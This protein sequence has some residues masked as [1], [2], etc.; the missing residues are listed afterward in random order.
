M[1]VKRSYASHARG[2]AVSGGGIFED[3]VFWA[4]FA[5][6]GGGAL[7][8]L[9]DNEVVVKGASFVS[10]STGQG[11]A[12]ILCDGGTF[13]QILIYDNTAYFG[14]GAIRCFGDATFSNLTIVDN[15]GDFFAL[16]I[17]CWGAPV[18]SNVIIAFHDA[19]TDE[20]VITCEGGA[21]PTFYCCNIYGNETGDWV[22][23]IADQYGV[24]DNIS[25]DPQFCD[26]GA[27]DFRISASSPCAPQNSGCGELIGVFGVGCEASTTEALSWGRIKALYRQH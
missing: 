14:A 21:S 16:A 3:V 20:P 5:E 11:G 19:W 13:E 24:N 8:C 18:F 23:C 4:N 9:Y 2:G 22:G 6:F 26:M 25:A 10:N 15:E 17:E 1:T 12:A 7:Y 27:G